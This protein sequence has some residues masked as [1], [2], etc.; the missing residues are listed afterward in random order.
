MA[1][2][3]ELVRS[4]DEVQP[5]SVALMAALE[6]ITTSE[7]ISREELVDAMCEHIVEKVDRTYKR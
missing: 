4:A 5:N 1:H 3:L 7:G 2:V 6:K